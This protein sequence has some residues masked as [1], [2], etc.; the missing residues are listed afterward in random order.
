[1]S[2]FATSSE[3]RV[4]ISGK[5]G[6]G[7]SSVTRIIGERLGLRVINYTFHDMA[8][9]MGISF[10][11]LC[12]RAERDDGYDRH[13]DRKQVE[14]AAAP[15]CVL[16]SRLAIW[17]LTD[18]DL[19]VYLDGSPEIRAARVARR[20]GTGSAETLAATVERDRRDRQRYLRLYSID[21]DRFE[22]ADLVVDTSLGDQEYV[23]DR[24]IDALRGRLGRPKVR[25]RR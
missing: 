2:S 9:E 13:L 20:E 16:G 11:E 12:E 22:H 14:L 24:I 8:V 25:R 15:G 21:I 7:N 5:S 6:C 3:A 17:L 10:D 18:A 1:M 19:K 23:A 4:A